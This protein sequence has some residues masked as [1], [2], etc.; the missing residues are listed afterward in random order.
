M[1]LQCVAESCAS[2]GVDAEGV[3]DGDSN[4]AF[5]HPTSSW[6]AFSSK[7]VPIE[8]IMRVARRGHVPQ[9]VH[10]RKSVCMQ[11]SSLGLYIEKGSTF[12]AGGS[13]PSGV[14]P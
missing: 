6:E 9:S 11:V 5:L 13:S 8:R 7:R 2:V 1:H 10:T 3:S 14:Y 4:G 12:F